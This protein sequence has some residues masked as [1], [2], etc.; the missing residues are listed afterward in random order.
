[1]HVTLDLYAPTELEAFAK[2]AEALA[3]SRRGAA[4][5]P[6][7]KLGIGGLAAG[8]E[9]WRNQASQNMPGDADPASTPEPTDDEKARAGTLVTNTPR[10][11]EE[12]GKRR[13]RP[14]KVVEGLT[15]EPAIRVT[16]EDRQPLAEDPQDSADEAEES[17]TNAGP[18]LTHD[19]VRSV[20]GAYMKKYGM[21]AAQE[22]G[23]GFL[24]CAKISEIPDDQDAL[25]AA[26]EAVQA[27]I[28]ANPKG[29][30]VV[31]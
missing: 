2:F 6:L 26:V 15:V 1:M 17:E 13:G 12:P 25:R 16:P 7:N 3:Q 19:H 11:G 4:N 10:V 30:A 31:S 24:G 9:L 18:M 20:M 8:N 21:P 27:A 29:R 5:D 14:K 22:D 23:P 28:D